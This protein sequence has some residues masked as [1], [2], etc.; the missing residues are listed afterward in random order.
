M[1]FHNSELV[2][3]LGNGRRR[4]P[5]PVMARKSTSTK[6]SSGGAFVKSLDKALGLLETL[7]AADNALTLSDLAQRVGLPLPTIHRL[8]TTLER[9]KFVLFDNEQSRWSVGVRAFIVGNAFLPR[10]NLTRQALPVMRRLMEES[11]ETTNLAVESEGEAVFLAHVECHDMMRA[12]SRPGSRVA[13][14]CS[15]VGKALLSAMSRDE[16]TK[17]L[18]DHGLRPI[19]KTTVDTPEKM[20]A[21][22]DRIRHQGFSFDD[23][24]HAPGVRCVAAP[25]F[26]E[27]GRAL[28]AVSLSG[29]TTRITDDRVPGLGAQVAEAARQI[30]QT[31]GGVTDG[32]PGTRENASGR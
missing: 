30:T 4:P 29:P 22:L 16:V 13:L 14:Y 10:R 7:S 11:G 27:S 32:P 28:A 25:I 3:F 12:S 15:G 31:L 18:H 8:L 2:V 19:T 23:E 1:V 24:E 26:D 21:E 20:H 17:V 9:R 6:A 5:N